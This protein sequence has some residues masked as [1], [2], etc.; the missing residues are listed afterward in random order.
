MRW[1]CMGRASLGNL[2]E[3]SDGRVIPIPAQGEHSVTLLS[4]NVHLFSFL[5]IQIG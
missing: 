3:D 1:S 2:F 4:S 5:D